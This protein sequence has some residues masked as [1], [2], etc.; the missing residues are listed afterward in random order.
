VAAGA[1]GTGG[2]QNTTLLAGGAA[3]AAAGVIGLGY[4][5]R[6]RRAGAGV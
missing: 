1:E 2:E 3:I 5:V 4:V 6:R